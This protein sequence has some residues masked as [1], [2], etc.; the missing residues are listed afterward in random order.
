MTLR[1]HYAKSIMHFALVFFATF[2]NTNT[3]GQDSK[4]F[5]SDKL[6]SN[7]ATCFCQDNYG[8]VWI[9][10]QYGLNR[11]DGYK[12]KTYLHDADNPNSSVNDNSITTLFNDSQGRLWIGTRKGCAYY[13]AENDH[14]NSVMGADS[15]SLVNIPRVDCFCETKNGKIL[16]GTSGFGLFEINRN[17]FAIKK[18]SFFSFEDENDFYKLVFQD[19]RGRIWKIDNLGVISCFPPESNSRYILRE[20]S[21]L[22]LPSAIFETPQ[23]VTVVCNGGIMIFKDNKFK[24]FPFE[25]YGITCGTKLKNGDILLGTA[26]KGILRMRYKDASGKFEIKENLFPTAP[27]QAVFEDRDCNIWIACRNKGVILIPAKESKFTTWYLPPKGTYSFSCINSATLL[28]EGK[29]LCTLNDGTVCQLDTLGNITNTFRTSYDMG[30][31]YCAP[32]TGNVYLAE[33][34]AIYHA[35]NFGEKTSFI[36]KTDKDWISSIIEGKDG[37][38]YAGVHAGGLDVIDLKTLAVENLNMYQ[39]DRKGGYLCNNWINDMLIQDSLLW[40]ATVSGVTCYNTKSKTFSVGGHHNALEGLNCICFE[41]MQDGLI[42]IGSEKGLYFYSKEKKICEKFPGAEALEN[43]SVKKILKDSSGDLWIS[44]SSGLWHYKSQEKVFI[45]HIS[46]IGLSDREY[47]QNVGLKITPELF[48]FA[49]SK[50]FTAFNPSTAGFSNYNIDVPVLS[51]VYVNGKKISLKEQSSPVLKYGENNLS[52]DFTVFDYAE[53]EN[54][55]FEYSVNDNPSVILSGGENTVTFYN[56][57]AGSYDMKIRACQ[58]G[59]CSA[60]SKFHITVRPPW[61]SSGI[62]FTLYNLTFLGIL[63]YILHRLKIRKEQKVYEEKTKVLIN[64]THDIR[65]PLTMIISPLHQLLE[66]EKSQDKLRKLQI[67]NS[68]ANRILNLVNQILYLRKHDRQQI[69]LYCRKTNLIEYTESSVKIF[70]DTIKER[71]IKFSIIK[72][73]EE[74]QIYIDTDNFDKVIINLVSNALKYTPQGGEITIKISKT[75]VAD[76]DYALLSVEDSGSGLSENDIKNIFSRFY[77]SKV[78]PGKRAEGTGIGLNICKMIVEQ[79][80]GT[81]T[82]ANR[83]DA[84][85]SIFSVMMPLGK[86]HLKEDERE[87]E[88]QESE[89]KEENTVKKSQTKYRILIVDDNIDIC[90]YISS[91]LSNIYR[92]SIARDGEEAI[93]IVL[94]EPIDLIV[95][96]IMMPKMDGFTLLRMI[97]SNVNTSHIPVILLSSRSEIANRLEGLDKGADAFLAKPFVIDELHSQIDNLLEKM[98]VLKGKFS[99]Q[100]DIIKTE[101]ET[102]NIIDNDKLLMEKIM[103]C[104]ND[105]ISDPDFNVEFLAKSICVSRAQIHRK[106]KEMTGINISDLI[107]NIRLEQAGR[108]IKEGKANVSQVAYSLGFNNLSHFSKAFKDHYGIPPS[109]YAKQA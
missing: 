59:S 90:N 5:S 80:H 66:E 23:G 65:T 67:I 29:V 55:F 104:I 6:S 27:V 51:G 40:I 9:G 82:A 106:M 39:K 37:K 60:Y 44:S 96:D 79:H 47:I 83:K 57:P 19:S 52:M 7:S 93:K 73:E 92:L 38:L 76:K 103:K 18:V 101:I 109:E 12:F 62:A 74:L 108:M 16:S 24:V 98:K 13:D 81:I 91:E 42:V 95:S 25:G 105:N 3:N 53:P 11:F 69:K 2:F 50:G 20:N 87:P 48:L 35:N 72:P 10:T 58:N 45:A 49:N 26:S 89:N 71:N 41:E 78:Q 34:S 30:L 102:K 56:L 70:E 54:T 33:G 43:I 107:R 84:I 77:R 17:N 86:D 22:G 15:A 28:P 68:N 94:S 100:H 64:A 21:H 75:N 46:D 97:K 1:E 63:I 8:F 31:I 32:K 14:I 85:G 4:F 99:G 36:A 61:Y 88:I